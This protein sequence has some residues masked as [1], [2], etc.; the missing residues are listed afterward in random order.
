MRIA[1]S[2]ASG[3]LGTA[4]TAALEPQ[5]EVIRLVRRPTRTYVE[6][7]WDPAA[8][9]IEGQGLADVDAVV[10][11]SGAGLAEKKWT[12]R[13]KRQLLESRMR[14]TVAL[15]RHARASERCGLLLQASAIGYYGNSGDRVVDETDLNGRGFLAGLVTQWEGAAP[16][17]PGLRVAYLRTGLVLARS[18]GVLGLQLPLFR[19]GLGGR[20]GDGTQWQSWISLTDWVRA[21]RHL[22]TSDVPDEHGRP[23][24][25]V[26]PNPVTNADFTERLGHVLR[27]PTPLPIPLPVVRRMLGD[28][29]VDEAL[30]YSTRVAPRVLEADGFTF[31]HPDLGVALRAILRT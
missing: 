4:L 3:L 10:N 2:G 22:L 25:L 12:P 5:H 14:T 30:L 15:H 9:T 16:G 26:S 17:V 7:R 28:E 13:R 11:L 31:D 18:G 8:G 24:N 29:L 23:V 19:L 20:V 27:R 21:V 1:V 6:R